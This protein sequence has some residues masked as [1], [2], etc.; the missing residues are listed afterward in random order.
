MQGWHRSKRYHPQ[1]LI[2]NRSLNCST[3]KSFSEINN[4]DCTESLSIS[5]FAMKVSF[6]ISCSLLELPIVFTTWYFPFDLEI[7]CTETLPDKFFFFLKNMPKSTN[8]TP[9]VKIQFNKIRVY[10]G[11]FSKVRKTGESEIGDGRLFFKWRFVPKKICRPSC[12]VLR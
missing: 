9:I 4:W 1:S 8:G 7:S 12:R 10:R 2:L 11:C 6:S 5:C 3:I